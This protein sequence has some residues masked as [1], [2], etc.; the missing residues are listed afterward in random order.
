MQHEDENKWQLDRKVSVANLLAVV[1]AATALF[2]YVSD[3]KTEVSV[4]ANAHAEMQKT[5][6]I[7]DARQDAERQEM[8]KMWRED[9]RLIHEKLDRIAAGQ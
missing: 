7:T 9:M 8:R 5:Q 4:I 3:I 2:L 6:L 1:S